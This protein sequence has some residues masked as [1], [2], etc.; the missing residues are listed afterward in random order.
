MSDERKCNAHP[1]K[2]QT[3]DPKTQFD[4]LPTDQAAEPTSAPSIG[5]AVGNSVDKD[6]VF[7]SIDSAVLRDGGG[8]ERYTP[9]IIHS[10]LR[11]KC[12][13][14]ERHQQRLFSPVNQLGV[15]SRL[16]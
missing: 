2:T 8:G 13:S 1:T 5:D 12:L 6:P 10:I 15:T 4:T 16:E 3:V 7:K 9:R 14:L 11:P